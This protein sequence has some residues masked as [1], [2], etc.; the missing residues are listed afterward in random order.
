[1]NFF[2]QVLATI[3]GLTIFQVISFL[4]LMIFIGLIASSF[5]DGG[6]SSRGLKTIADNS[7]LVLKLDYDIEERDGYSPFDLNNLE[8][9]SP[10]KA[11]LQ[12]LLEAIEHAQNND[13]IKGIYMDLS[14]TPNE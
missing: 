7:L 5:G 3:V 2:K 9:I 4:M 14:F 6:G 13:K 1:M 8:N 10:E 12:S 11:G